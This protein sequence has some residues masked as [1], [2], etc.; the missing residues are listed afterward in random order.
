[1]QQATIL[2]RA[3]LF[4]QNGYFDIFYFFCAGSGIG[5]VAVAENG[6]YHLTFCSSGPP[7]PLTPPRTPYSRPLLP[8]PHLVLI[9]ESTR[10]SDLGPRKLPFG[11]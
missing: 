9:A 3:L 7:L 4:E 1:V 5:I 6:Y 10:H 2:R 11:V 8:S